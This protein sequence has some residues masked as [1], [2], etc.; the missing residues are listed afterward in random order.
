MVSTWMGDPSSVDAVATNTV[1][2]Q[3][4]RNGASNICFWG[5]KRKKKRDVD[6][7]CTAGTGS[8]V[9]AC[10]PLL[11]GCTYSGGRGSSAASGNTAGARRASPSHHILSNDLKVLR[12]FIAREAGVLKL[13]Y[14]DGKCRKIQM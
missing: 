14:K 13:Y 4:W 3:K 6:S 8:F 9:Q 5:K 1:Q 12:I 7:F 10:P 11:S 2:S